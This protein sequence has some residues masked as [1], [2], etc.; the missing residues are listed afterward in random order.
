M[1]YNYLIFDFDGV[2]A[3]SN[4]IR[5]DGF[6]L[7][8]KGYPEDKVKRLLE[9]A[10]ANGGMSRYDKIRYFFKN[11]LK[12]A[13]SEEKVMLF[14]DRYS[15]LVK[16]RVVN[17][18]PV[19]GSLEFLSEYRDRF[20]FAIVSGSDQEELR[21]VCRH[22]GIKDYFV[23]ILGS[24]ENKERNIAML[25]ADKGWEKSMCAFIGDSINDLDAAKANK[26]Y[27]IARNSNIVDWKSL[28][29]A[30]IE[31]LSQLYQYLQKGEM[32][33]GKSSDNNSAKFS[34]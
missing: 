19:K 27:F 24:P 32:D 20:K 11:I 34:G 6:R 28:G 25:L 17:A 3:E 10:I 21:D 2:L 13:V 31:D 33:Y 18:Q 30:C 23:E 16:A 1:K 14:A 7:L 9:Y 4:D 5:F 8:F 12:E 15:K 29:V 22:R 26:V